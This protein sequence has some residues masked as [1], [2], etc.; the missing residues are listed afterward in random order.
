MIDLTGKNFG[1]WR[2][3]KRHDENRGGI[4]IGFIIG[5]DRGS[6]ETENYLSAEFKKAIQELRGEGC[7]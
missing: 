1:C 2:V 4:Y 7:E 6:T 3:W 5:H